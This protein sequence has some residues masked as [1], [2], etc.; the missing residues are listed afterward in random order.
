MIAMYNHDSERYLIGALLQDADLQRELSTLPD[1]L[2]HDPQHETIFAT[3]KAMQREKQPIEILSVNNRLTALGKQIQGGGY[4]LECWRYCPTTA[5][6]GHYTAE[7]KRLCAMRSAYRLANTFCHKLTDGE[8]LAACVDDLRTKLREAN[9]PKGRLMR[10]NDVALAAF[11]YVDK[12]HKGQ[13]VGLQT[14]FPDYDRFTGGLFAGELTILGARPAVGK[15]ALGMEIGLNVAR[16][17]KRVL[18]CSREMNE[19]QYGIRLA[20]NLSGLNGMT[21]KNGS[22]G[23]NQ[24]EPLHVAMNDMAALPISFTFD[25]F[26]IE[27]LHSLVQHEVDTNGLDLL[28]VDYLQL[29]GTL[30]KSEKRYLEVGAVSRGLKTMAMEF[31]IPIIALAQVG[32]PKDGKGGSRA[33]VCPVMSE[34][35]ESGNIEQDADTIA[36]LHH[37]EAESDP[38]IIERDKAT[39]AL[40][41]SH[42]KQYVVLK[43]DKQ[44]MGPKG[45]FGMCFDPARMRFTCLE[46]RVV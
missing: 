23:D 10:M 26:A 28:V 25:T 32:R 9:Q 24:W 35:R 12:K 31:R 29:M 11:D 6:I 38:D 40:L 27:D 42:D 5:N 46:R 34:L 22:L 36:F 30:Q 14:G 2:M 21:L 33:A 37:P 8:D 7:L 19:L 44:R 20:S 4:L 15:S 16:R 43:F 18:V 39:R 3:M 1:D 41:E 17:G 13:I 45:S